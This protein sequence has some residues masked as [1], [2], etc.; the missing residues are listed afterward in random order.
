MRARSVPSDSATLWTLALQAPLSLGFSGQEHWSG[1]PSPSPEDLPGSGMEHTSPAV[2]GTFF[3]TGNWEV[4]VVLR[5]D[6]S[7]PTPHPSRSSQNVIYSLTNRH[8]SDG[9]LVISVYTLKV[10][11]LE[12][13]SVC[14][15]GV[16]PKDKS[17]VKFC[18]WT[19]C[20]VHQPLS[21]S[22]N[23]EELLQLLGQ[24]FS[25]LPTCGKSLEV[26]LKTDTQTLDP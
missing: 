13:S 9:L 12:N 14:S 21:C 6:R 16:L 11:F 10:D 26:F 22:C 8:F 1:L 18:G 24:W 25:T 5:P 4:P 2:A 15:S 7:P 3:T 23:S 17:K 19:G 20:Q